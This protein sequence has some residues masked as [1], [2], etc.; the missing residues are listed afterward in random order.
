MMRDA[1]VE[2][3]RASDAERERAAES[4]RQHHAEGR[5]TTEE[6]EERTER[7][8]AATTLGDLDELFGDLP[9]VRTPDRERGTRRPW[10][11]PPALALPL[12]ALVTIAIAASTHGL[13]LAWPLMF[14][15]LFRF[16]APHRRPWHHRS[17]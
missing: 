1:D 8:Y 17:R 5:V 12:L 4:L 3:L 15:V 11:W 14:F 6:F 9:R 2:G 13:W 7:A 16:A 10:L